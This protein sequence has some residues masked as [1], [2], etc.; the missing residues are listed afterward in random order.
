MIDVIGSGAIG[1][2]DGSFAK[3]TFD[4]PQGCALDK[5]TL[6]VADTEN[7]MLRKVDLKAKTVS[8]IAGVGQQAK[9]PGQ[10]LTKLKIAVIFPNGSSASR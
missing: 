3:A 9:H 7:H 2:D 6:Y 8:T 1:R 10:D 4:H 5:E